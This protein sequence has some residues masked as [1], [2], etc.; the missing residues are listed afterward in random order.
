MLNEVGASRLTGCKEKRSFD[1]LRM[2][3]TLCIAH[4]TTKNASTA[5]A[6]CATLQK[7]LVQLGKSTL[8]SSAKAPC[9]ARQK[10][11]VSRTAQY[12]PPVQ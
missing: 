3:D 8:C 4:T 10:R 12:T 6:S 2:T 5:K 1:K 11:L 7:H 9:A